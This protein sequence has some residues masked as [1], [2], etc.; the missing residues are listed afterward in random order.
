MRRLCFVSKYISCYVKSQLFVVCITGLEFPDTLGHSLPSRA[1]TS[2]PRIYNKQTR[3]LTSLTKF[4]TGQHVLKHTRRNKE[5]TSHPETTTEKSETLCS[6]HTHPKRSTTSHSM[7]YA[8][9][10]I[11]NLKSWQITLLANHRA[12]TAW[13]IYL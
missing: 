2:H 13:N 6:G 10:Q 8:H 1:E 4:I 5:E 11:R 9:K 12:Y 3:E 7:T